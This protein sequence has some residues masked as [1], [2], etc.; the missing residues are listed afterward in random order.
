M[1]RRRWPKIPGSLPCPGGDVAVKVVSPAAIMKYADPGEELFGC[2]VQ[3]ERTIY[4]RSTIHGEPRWRVL[5]HE[6][7]HVGLEDSGLRNGLEH[8]LEEAICDALTSLVMRV[9][10]DKPSN[11]APPD[12]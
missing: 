6:L 8:Q 5:W 11:P 3:E 4:L 2:Y 9:V 10:Y 12:E 7:M 1:P